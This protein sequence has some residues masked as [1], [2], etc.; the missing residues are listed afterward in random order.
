MFFALEN[1]R[2]S[3]HSIEQSHSSPIVEKATRT[4]SNESNREYKHVTDFTGPT[5]THTTKVRDEINKIS[6]HFM[7]NRNIRTQISLDI[8]MFIFFVLLFFKR[9]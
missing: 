6:F 7:L 8:E 1:D 4:L 5:V 3:P 9:I 2:Q